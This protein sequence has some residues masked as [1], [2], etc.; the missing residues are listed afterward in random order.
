MKNQ[1][2]KKAISHSIL[3]LV[4]LGMLFSKTTL[5]QSYNFSD[6]WEKEGFTM[7]NTDDQ[8]IQ[9]NYSIEGFSLDSINTKEGEFVNI[10]FSNSF[11]PADE[12]LPNTPSISRYIAVPQNATI[13]LNIINSRTEVYEDVKL[14][15]AFRIPWDTENKPLDYIK[16][17]E[18]YE[19]DSFFP[20]NPALISEII[21]FRGV[22]V[23]MLSISPFQY[24]PVKKQLMVSRDI[25]IKIEMENGNGKYGEERL[26]NKW[27]E[28]ILQDHILNYSSMP[29]ADFHKNRNLKLED[30]AE[31][32]IVC[33]NDSEFVQWADS[34]KKFRTEQGI[35]TKVVTLAE[36]GGNNVNTLQSYFQ[37]AMDWQIPPAAVLL[38]GDYGTNADNRIISPVWNNYCVSD[39]MFADV[40]GDGMPEM[41]FARMT[42]RNET[43]LETMVTKFI[44]YET[45][46]PTNP[47]YYN[48]PITA[49]GWQTERWFQICS[50]TVGGFW[51][52][53]LGKDPV[54][55]NEIYE[56]TPATS[57]WSTAQNTNTVVNYFGPNGLGYIPASPTAL[58]NWSG[59]DAQDVTD[60][61]NAGAFMLQ[62]RDHGFENGWGEPYFT[63]QDIDNLTNTDLCF[64][65]SVNCLTG[66][67][68]LGS[69]CFT[70]KL[71]RYKHNGQNAGALGLLA[72]SEVSYSFVN[73]T[74]VW[75]MY[76]NMWPEFLPDYGSQVEERGLLP[77][78]GMAAGKYFLQTSNWPSNAINKEVTYNLFHHHG[79]AFLQLYSE[80][81]QELTVI[82]NQNHVSGMDNFMV[83]VD[84]G[85]TVA[86]TNNG[87]ILSTAL[88]DGTTMLLYTGVL[89]AGDEMIVTITKQNHYRYREIVEVITLNQPYC[90]TV[91]CDINDD[92]G[93]AN[94]FIDYGENILLT[95]GIAN[96]GSQ[97]GSNISVEI[98]CEDEFVT[99]IDGNENYGDIASFETI[100]IEDAFEIAI[101]DNVPDQHQILI[102][103]SMTDGNEVWNS[104]IM[105]TANAPVLEILEFS[106]D[107]S[108]NG[109]GNDRLEPGEEATLY[110]TVSN[111]GNS[112]VD[113]VLAN[114]IC[115]N[116]DI[117]ISQ[118]QGAYGELLTDESSS[119]N[120]I[121]S[122]SE[123]CTDGNLVDFLLEIDS[124]YGA[125]SNQYFQVL[126]GRYP[127]L[128]LDVSLESQSGD[129]FKD[130]LDELGIAYEYTNIFQTSFSK[131]K[132]LIISLGTYL[133]NYPLNQSN[134]NHLQDYLD[135][136]GSIYMEGRSTWYHDDQLPIH[137]M[138][139][140]NANS[141]GW[142]SLDTIFGNP[143]TQTT[144]MVF[145][146]DGVNAINNYYLEPEEG[147]FQFLG[148]AQ[149]ELG[150]A[151]AYDNG[152][153]K[154][155]GASI[156][157]G[158][159]IDGDSPSTKAEF[160]YEILQFLGVVESGLVNIENNK[161]MQSITVFPNPTNGKITFNICAEYEVIVYD[162]TGRIVNYSWVNENQ[163]TIDLSDQETGL[164]FIY[165]GGSGNHI[166]KVIV[167]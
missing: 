11:L 161:K 139:N 45:N 13:S 14:A 115:D 131:Y 60:A 167:E 65:M 30:G 141:Q 38:L 87:E 27:W 48:H 29:K 63:S 36:I 152:T 23:V 142:F 32:L 104:N 154:T 21:N 100:E 24:N 15:P 44:N 133:S 148:N 98:S 76:D 41:I 64:I 110:I 47:D 119:A 19:S 12:G 149:E 117:S 123:D 7:L 125:I 114:L 130:A 160:L 90:A 53:E 118:S 112:N 102:E 165:L 20:A 103:F 129:A 144:G 96:M 43:E 106:I 109:N 111:N 71:H 1:N 50:E 153:Y 137:D 155:I 95:V 59:G 79:D 145:L 58:G 85:A 135:Q 120:Y 150:C 162:I 113:N 147:S 22:N 121:I 2:L 108:A 55:I 97:N 80:V 122:A 138:F 163:P 56:G 127:V 52:N 35:L 9:I 74:Y 46:P 40:N 54:R 5:A 49:L 28:P 91:S 26:R 99:I 51:K 136:G 84:A 67:Y 70:E 124:D 69:E 86:I 72:A 61:I 116:E 4:I 105:L 101:A 126:V 151:I 159:L 18:A 37:D 94:G 33:P 77:A 158:A 82:H 164:Y 134:S 66:K 166:L 75:G 62:H 89:E 8:S 6:A 92:S 68:N 157:Y 73:D 88:S 16:N 132:S 3:F 25:E 81:P 140:L 146:Y 128:I 17:K 93:N 57:P 107:D 39:N 156:E 34:I 78:F 42:A 143:Q 31:Y 83:Q 10:R